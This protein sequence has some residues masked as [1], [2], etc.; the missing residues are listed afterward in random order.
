MERGDYFQHPQIYP[1]SAPEFYG[2]FDE[3]IRN[4]LFWEKMMQPNEPFDFASN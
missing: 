4:N 3:N 2:D 1:F